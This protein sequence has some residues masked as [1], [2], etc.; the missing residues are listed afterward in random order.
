MVSSGIREG[1]LK[2]LEDNLVVN[3]KYFLW[4][5]Q[6][7]DGIPKNHKEN[8]DRAWVGRRSSSPGL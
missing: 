6:G 3:S 4:P 8:Q 1:V 2:Y 5:K 7:T